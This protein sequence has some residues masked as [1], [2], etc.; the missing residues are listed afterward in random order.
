MAMD[1]LLEVHELR[2]GYGATPILQGV[3]FSVG[4]GEIVAIIG[5]NG[6]GKT[7]LMKCLIGLLQPQWSWLAVEGAA[8]LHPFIWERLR[9]QVSQAPHR[10]LAWIRRQCGQY[11]LRGVRL[12]ADRESQFMV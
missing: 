7:T 6:V 8:P 5:R 11:Q 4:K 10:R 9:R 3:E 12:V 1:P 2:A